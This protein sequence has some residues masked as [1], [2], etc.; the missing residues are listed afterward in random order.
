[1][2]KNTPLAFAF[3]TALAVP[4]LSEPPKDLDACAKLSAQTAKDAKIKTEA[5][6][7]K[8]HFKL[9]DLQAACGAR[10]FVGAE[11]IANDI[12]AAYPADK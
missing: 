11:K 4:A 2:L 10:D 6:Y 7:V 5:D 8:F 1:V 9:M 12:K 3:L